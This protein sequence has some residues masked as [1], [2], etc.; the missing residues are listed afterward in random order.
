MFHANIDANYPTSFPP[1]IS[2]HIDQRALERQPC[3]PKLFIALASVD[4][5]FSNLIPQNLIKNEN[6]GYRVR[7][8]AAPW[9]KPL[10]LE[11]SL[12]SETP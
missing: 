5:A 3:T 1:W 9:M 2:N 7:K 12:T 10:K 6:G 11:S 8:L 4:V